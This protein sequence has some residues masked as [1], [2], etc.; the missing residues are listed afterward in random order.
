MNII[1]V[2]KSILSQFPKISVTGS[3]INIDLTGDEFVDEVESDNV[4]F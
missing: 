2:M 1:E 4:Y 3:D